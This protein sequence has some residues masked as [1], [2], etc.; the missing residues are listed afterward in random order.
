MTTA[1]I[2]GGGLT[3]SIR[4]GSNIN[5]CFLKI[6]NIPVILYS[7]RVFKMNPNIDRVFVSLP[8]KDH[9]ALLAI[10]KKHN[11]KGVKLFLP[12]NTRMQS[13]DK[14]LNEAKFDPEELLLIHD[15]ARPFITQKMVD[16]LLIR[17]RDVDAAVVGVRRK[18]NFGC[19]WF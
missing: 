11:I 12:S 19:S 7:I 15:G 5:K 10:L 4:M 6:N 13:I 3:N 14:I 16:N 2:V 17:I 1:I 18:R 8:I 9:K